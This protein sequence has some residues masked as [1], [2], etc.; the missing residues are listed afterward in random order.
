MAISKFVD[1]EHLALWAQRDMAP[2]RY[3]AKFYL[4]LHRVYYFTRY[5]LRSEGDW[6]GRRR[7]FNQLQW[8]DLRTGVFFVW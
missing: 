4:I 6:K 3:T 2:L 8:T 5:A 7:V 1:S